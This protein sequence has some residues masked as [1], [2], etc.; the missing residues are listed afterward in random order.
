MAVKCSR[1]PNIVGTDTQCKDIGKR[2]HLGAERGH[3]TPPSVTFDF[4]FC[5]PGTERYS[6][7]TT[8]EAVIHEDNPILSFSDSQ[9]SCVP[10]R[11]GYIMRSF[12]IACDQKFAYLARVDLAKVA[13]SFDSRVHE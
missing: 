5:I 11:A 13:R 10:R 9:P 2:K 7:S 3:E 12:G 1:S 6:R 4:A 8:A